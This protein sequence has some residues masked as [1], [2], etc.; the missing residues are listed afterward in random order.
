MHNFTFYVV[1]FR[2]RYSTSYGKEP[3][4][5]FIDGFNYAFTFPYKYLP[6]PFVS[7]QGL[8]F[9]AYIGW[10]CPGG[11]FGIKLTRI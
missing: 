6:L 5:K 10:R 8:K 1:G 9:K 4:A 7:Y 3:G 11:H 2:D